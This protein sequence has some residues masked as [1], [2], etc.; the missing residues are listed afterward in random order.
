MYH[1][2]RAA[3]YAPPTRTLLPA[4][5]RQKRLHRHVFLWGMQIGLAMFFIGAGYAKL[6]QSPDLLGYLVGWTTLVSPETVRIAG[7]LEIAGAAGV[8]ASLVTWR[9]RPV[10]IVGALMICGQT[11]LMAV[12]HG[13]EANG[14]LSILHLQLTIVNLVLLAMAAVVVVGR[15]DASYPEPE[16]RRSPT[17]APSRP[18]ELTSSRLHRLVDGSVR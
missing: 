11:T 14:Q 15:W 12:F 8:L 18:M 16:A 13:L 7:W 10:V 1:M 9:L 5:E 17:S 4:V 2:P 3:G 6:T